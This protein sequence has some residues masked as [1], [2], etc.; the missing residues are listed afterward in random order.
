MKKLIA[1]VLAL[2]TLAIAGTASAENHNHDDYV[3]DHLTAF[4]R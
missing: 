2:A 3:K 4:G 1:S